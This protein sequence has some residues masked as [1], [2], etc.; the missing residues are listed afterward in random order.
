VRVARDEV[1]RAADTVDGPATLQLRSAS[2]CEVSARAWGPGA[3]RAIDSVPELVGADDDPPS[4]AGAH[5]LIDELEH[6]IPGLR[7]G[8]TGAVMETLVPTVLEQKVIGLEAKR[9]HVAMV[10][11]AGRRA[12]SA[13]S[14]APALFLPP[15]PGWLV[16]VPSWTF[17]RW[18]VERKRARTIQVA[19]SY[20]HRF[21]SVD[22]A[23]RQRLSALPGVGPWTCNT[24][25]SIALGDPDAVPVGDYWL[26]HIVSNALTGEPRGSDERMLELLE[27]WRGQR[28]RVCR[29]LRYGGPSLPRYGPRLALRELATHEVGRVPGRSRGTHE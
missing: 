14:C 11:A 29:L 12:P 7:I 8:C 19:A 13:G 17:H 23:V 24:V 1:W 3:A 26:K 6:A 16:R 20:A 27:P 25:A 21:R 9:S 5:P 4:L 28:G 2:E 18:G 10:R 22:P 15:E